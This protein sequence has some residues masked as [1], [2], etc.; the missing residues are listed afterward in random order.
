MVFDVV[1]VG[2][3][4]AG[5]ACAR[6]LAA[7]GKSVRV[8]ERSR[9]VG[10][11]CATRRIDGQP[12]DHGVVFLHGQSDEFIE[13]LRQVPG[14]RLTQWPLVVR[15]NG[16]PCQPNAFVAGAHRWAH[17]SGVSAFPKYLA[18][19][20]DVALETNV[21]GISVDDDS[22]RLQTSQRGETGE[23]RAR[24]LA[25][26]IAGPQAH[27]LL[28]QESLAIKSRSA[29]ALLS[30]MPSVPCATV[31]ALYEPTA[32]TTPDWDIWYPET[33]DSLLLVAHDSAKRE[34][35][36]HLALVLQANPAWSSEVAMAADSKWP[37]RL[38]R[39]AA[40]LLGT[41]ALHPTAT[42]GHLWHYARANP[43]CEMTSPI[44][45]DFEN[46]R[47]LGLAGELFA[48]GG[49]LQAAWSSGRLLARR[50]LDEACT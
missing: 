33:S 1:V 17:P 11:R 26:A 32:V 6:Y 41:W 16:M 47:R 49:G 5:L 43:D 15:G 14:H 50:L 3:G 34:K 45:I 24:D 7:A 36:Q 27:T 42:Q 23:V 21:T 18:R 25:L 29:S 19:G 12:I 39:S 35:P 22:F 44:L 38:L 13:E 48:T 46:R 31:L 9:G 4:V 8:L 20:L 37:E 10:G 30:M 2:A 40:D 28:Q